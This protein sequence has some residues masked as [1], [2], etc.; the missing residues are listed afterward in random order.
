M[1]YRLS[2]TV[3]TA[4]IASPAAAAETV[5]CTCGPI[6]PPGDAVVVLLHWFIEFTVG[7]NGVTATLKLRRGAAT[8]STLINVGAAA[9]VVAPN[10]VR[11]GGSY[12]DSPG[13]V[14]EQQYS[15]TLTVGSASAASTV[16]DVCLI[17]AVL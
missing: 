1:G 6:N 2:T 13:A 10:V 7:T 8:S 17:A 12:F 3:S 15:L 9:T 5:I 4:V 11:F 14:A 16:S